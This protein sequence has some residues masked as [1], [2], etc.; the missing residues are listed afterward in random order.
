M[1]IDSCPI[2]SIA[3]ITHTHKQGVQQNPKYSEPFNM[4]GLDSSNSIVFELLLI[5]MNLI[6]TKS[7]DLVSTLEN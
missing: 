3:S 7:R 4:W 5:I 6:A 1:F 2:N